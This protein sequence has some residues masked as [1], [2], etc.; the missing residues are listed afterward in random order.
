MIHIC[1]HCT[2]YYCCVFVFFFSSRRRHTRFD[3][4]WSS[5]V[6]SSDLFA[7]CRECLQPPRSETI[8]SDERTAISSGSTNDH[9]VSN[10]RI[11]TRTCVIVGLRHVSSS[12]GVESWRVSDPALARWPKI[13]SFTVASD[14]KIQQPQ[15]RYLSPV[16]GK[17]AQCS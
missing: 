8:G 5:D 11:R 6:C 10:R 9:P 12:T 16:T 3:C 1:C 14:A 7:R 15:T 17:P 4:D 2:L 13:S